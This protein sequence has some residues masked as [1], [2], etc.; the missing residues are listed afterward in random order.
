M[1]KKRRKGAFG[2]EVHLSPFS[3]HEC[4]LYLQSRGFDW[5]DYQIIQCYMTFGGVPFY[6][7]LLDPI[8]SL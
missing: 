6:L 7:S 5:D 1:Q 8:I 4:K 2:K 3:L